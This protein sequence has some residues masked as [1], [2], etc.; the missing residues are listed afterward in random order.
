MLREMMLAGVVMVGVLGSTALAEAQV[1]VNAG[2][3]LG[4]PAAFVIVPGS[5]VMYAPSV[6]SN[7]FSYQGV[8]YVFQQ[9]VWYMAPRY[10]GPWVVVAPEFVPRP[11]LVVPVRYYKVPP[12]EWQYWRVEAAPHW[13]PAYGRRWEEWHETVPDVRRVE[14]R[15]PRY[16]GERR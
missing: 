4:S 13:H 7:V 14:H 9:G 10:G 11:L 15:E 3:R 8:Y 5:P 6:N 16:E 2:I 1:S 12:P